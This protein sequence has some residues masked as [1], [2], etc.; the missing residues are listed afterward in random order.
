MKHATKAALEPMAELLAR[1]D[2]LP[3]VKRKGI[4]AGTSIDSRQLA[5]LCG[6]AGA[7]LSQPV[8]VLHARRQRARF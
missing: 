3:N 4:G 6:A 1:L 7:L 8:N 5:N 2:A